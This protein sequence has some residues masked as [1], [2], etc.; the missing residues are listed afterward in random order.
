MNEAPEVW[1]IIPA[2]G[3]SKGIPRKNIKPIAGKP[4]IAYSIE[5]AKQSRFITRV[6]VNTE[7]EEIAFVA[8][9]LGAEVF[10]RPKEFSQDL[11]TDFE[12]YFHELTVHQKEGKLPDA[13]IQLRPN[14]PCRTVE[15]IDKGIA[16][17]LEHPEA[18]SVRAIMESAKH[19]FKMWITDGEYLKPFIPGHLHGIKDAHDQP[20]QKL[21]KVYI[22]TAAVD[23]MRPRTILEKKSMTGKIVR[24]FEM[25]PEHCVN[26][27]N[28]LDFRVAEQVLLERAGL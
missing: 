2:R 3:G 13:I 22:H 21:P 18:D 11:S 16:L 5:Q 17:L 10:V 26:I 15:D 9:S 20:R 6:I 12:V 19:P 4:M 14:L 1:A 8:R 23:V 7:D 24:Y 27:D 25:N 28:M